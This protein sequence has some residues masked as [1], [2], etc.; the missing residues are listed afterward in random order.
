MASIT[1]EP[2]L[3]A[4]SAWNFVLFSNG[5]SVAQNLMQKLHDLCA[6]GEYADALPLQEMVSHYWQIFQPEYPSP[7]KAAMGT[8]GRPVARCAGRCRSK[9]NRTYF[10]LCVNPRACQTMPHWG[11]IDRCI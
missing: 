3:S 10:S 9:V 2:L 7:I 8:M 1:I 4:F 5:C 6:A 11:S